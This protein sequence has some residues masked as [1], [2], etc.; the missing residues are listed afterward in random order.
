MCPA[1]TKIPG[2]T[3]DDFGGE[4]AA[5]GQIAAETQSVRKA[6][7]LVAPQIGSVGTVSQRPAAEPLRVKFE[8]VARQLQRGQIHTFESRLII[9]AMDQS[10]FD[11]QR[12]RQF[13]LALV[14]A[15]KVIK[16]DR[17]LQMETRRDLVVV[18]NLLAIRSLHVAVGGKI[19]GRFRPAIL[20]CRNIHPR[21]RVRF[22]ATIR[23]CPSRIGLTTVDQTIGFRVRSLA[24]L[25]TR[26]SGQRNRHRRGAKGNGD[27]T[28][29]PDRNRATAANTLLLPLHVVLS[30]VAS[31][32]GRCLRR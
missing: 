11:G 2:Q 27:D 14:V 13:H 3:V 1:G 16:P 17:I 26:T 29:R 18:L 15:R 23:Q 10:Q 9:A 25:G 31:K 7:Q 30:I 19:V 20:L 21:P 22:D 8:S 5:A 4:L 12:L 6:K 28:S 32:S 24:V